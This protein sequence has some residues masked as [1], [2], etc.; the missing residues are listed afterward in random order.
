[1]VTLVGSVGRKGYFIVHR[2]NI[3]LLAINVFFQL[4]S[5]HKH[6]ENEGVTLTPILQTRQNWHNHLPN[7]III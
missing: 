6:R 2:E 1:M 7:K 4:L 3:Q 5:H